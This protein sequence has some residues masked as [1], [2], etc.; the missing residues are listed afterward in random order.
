M[1][2]LVQCRAGNGQ[3]RTALG[4]PH[5]VAQEL[6]SPHPRHRRLRLIDP[7]L[8]LRVAPTQPFEHPLAS[9]QTAHID[10]AVVSVAHEPMAPALQLPIHFV[11]QHVGQQ[12][13]PL[14]AYEGVSLVTVKVG[15]EADGSGM[16][17]WPQRE[18]TAEAG[19]AGHQDGSLHRCTTPPP[20]WGRLPANCRPRWRIGCSTGPT[21]RTAV[22]TR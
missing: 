7:Q 20:A 18:A 9:P 13:S 16:Q 8:E 5:A 4:H 19:A 10:V 21:R 22:S 3:P 1:S 11:K 2:Q 12:R 15:S 17:V 14:R 6:A